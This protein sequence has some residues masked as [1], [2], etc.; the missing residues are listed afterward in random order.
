MSGRILESRSTASS[1][2]STPTTPTSCFKMTQLQKAVEDS[3]VNYSNHNGMNN[4][5]PIENKFEKAI[6]QKESKNSRSQSITS[7]E[8]LE[9]VDQIPNEL[10]QIDPTSIPKI[11][12]RNTSFSGCI[13]DKSERRVLVIYTG[14]TIGMIRSTRGG[15]S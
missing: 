1:G 14:G 13:L 10:T 11:L 6:K 5:S 2:S 7:D 4:N 3:G 8:V 15:N 12:R 9:S